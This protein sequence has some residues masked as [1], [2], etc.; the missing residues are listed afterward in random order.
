MTAGTLAGAGYFMG[1]RLYPPRPSNPKGFY[2]DVEVN[3]VNEAILTPVTPWAPRRFRPG[4]LYRLLRR[5]IFS[6]GFADGGRWLAQVP[7]NKLLASSPEIETRIQAL[8]EQA[9]Y[10]F[11]DPRFCYTLPIWRPWLQNTRFVCVFRDP[12]ISAK[13]ML[14][15][16]HT[17]PKLAG[18]KLTYA[19][20]LAVWRLMYTHVLDIHSQQGEWLFLHY[21]QVL[22]GSGLERLAEFLGAAPDR[23]FP[24]PTLRRTRP[25]ESMPDDVQAVYQ[26]L[27]RWAYGIEQEN[28]L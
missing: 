15:E 10:C 6:S 23:A 21:D 5:T 27:C 17:M 13:S 20:C 24:D 2:E 4:R 12:T 7:V 14:Q 26:S 25:G 8:V 19:D 1:E 11:K 9:P 3:A 18:L 16:S 22:D 28:L